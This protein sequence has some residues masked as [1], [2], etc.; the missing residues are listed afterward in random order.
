MAGNGY[1]VDDILEEI[2]RKKDGASAK[3]TDFE[4]KKES[5]E[6]KADFFEMRQKNTQP[7]EPKEPEA[8]TYTK[9]FKDE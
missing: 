2:R 6:P 3:P 9:K 4:I 8:P 1:S 7:E 5:S